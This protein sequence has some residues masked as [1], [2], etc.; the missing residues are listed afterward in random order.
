MGTTLF[1]LAAGGA[2]A[3]AGAVTRGA[4]SAAQLAVR[5]SP[6]V[7]TA[8]VGAVVVGGGFALSDAVN[9]YSARRGMASQFQN[10]LQFPN[11]LTTTTPFYISFG[12]QE[13]V[14]RSIQNSPFLR[15]TGSIR[16]PIPD[17]LKDTTSVTYTPTSLGG[18][19]AGQ[20]AGAALESLSN[21]P[22]PTGLITAVTSGVRVAAD[23]AK[24]A[25][26]GALNS[27]TDGALGNAARAYSGVTLNPYQ[28]ILF[29]RPEFKS[30][31]FTWKLVPKDGNESGTIRDIVRAFQFHMLPG[32]SDGI[33]LFFSFPSMVTVS[34]FPST[35][36]LYRFKPC[37]IS[38]VTVNYSPGPTPSF[39]RGTNAPTAV[40]I[41]VDLKEIE[42]FTNKDFTAEQ[43]NDD[44]AMNSYAM[45]IANAE[46]TQ[47]RISG[48]TSTERNNTGNGT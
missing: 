15:S 45:Q 30:H 1:R 9:L 7:Q 24:G 43:F 16:L 38:N 2:R 3:A 47:A 6:Y 8:V 18:G 29:E 4:G 12:F 22:R 33:G 46:N 31:S 28:T 39:Y 48:N 36:F 20:A 21:Q 32:V 13:Y 41:T 42:Y 35:E 44:I 10:Q 25:G 17:A 26:A 40:T 37:V 19:A 23:A 5:A 27:L 14:K 34:L 11:D